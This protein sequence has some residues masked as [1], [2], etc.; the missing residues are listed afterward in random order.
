MKNL[1]AACLI[2]CAGAAPAQDVLI[3]G[4]VHDNPAHHVTQAREVGRFAPSALVFEM[5]PAQAVEAVTPENRDDMAALRDALEWE[6]LGWPDFALYFPI[7]QAAPD[8]GIFGALVPRTQ[9]RRVMTE[10]VEAVFGP[11]ASRFG[12]TEPLPPPQ[13]AEREAAQMA[14]HCDALPV[15][16]LPGMVKIQRLRDATL[17]RAV[18]A[19]VAQTGGPVAVITGNGHARR[20]R[21]VPVYLARAAPGLTV[22]VVGQTEDDRALDG[23]FDSVL[24]APAVDR[25]DPCDVFR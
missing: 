21:G 17:A 20:D 10:G 14:A 22:E 15:A 2:G 24:S 23:R 1:L 19:A 4:E 16:V 3:L 25:P 8:A 5:L 7:F 13:Q 9:A 12:L 18:I 6:T 11:D